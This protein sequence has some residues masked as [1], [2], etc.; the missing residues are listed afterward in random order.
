MPAGTYQ[1]KAYADTYP[2]TVWGSDNLG[3]GSILSSRD[4]ALV[5]FSSRPNILT[6]YGNARARR[7]VA[8]G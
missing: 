7:P 4:P 8:S 5:D 6:T 1:H 3:I 2:G